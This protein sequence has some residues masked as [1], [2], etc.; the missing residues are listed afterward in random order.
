MESFCWN[1]S[2][3]NFESSS[4]LL[5]VINGKNGRLTHLEQDGEGWRRREEAI[6][7][8]PEERPV[9]E[10]QTLRMRIRHVEMT[11]EYRVLPT[12]KQVERVTIRNWLMPVCSQNPLFPS[13][14]TGE[15]EWSKS[16]GA[17]ST[18]YQTRPNGPFALQQFRSHLL[19]LLSSE[20]RKFSLQIVSKFQTLNVSGDLNSKRL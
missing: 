1:D 12:L 17:E 4:Q 16:D 3:R 15:S 5:H 6:G 10:L 11:G 20:L 2:V 19:L 8:I 14:S 9:F 7:R 18:F 13:L